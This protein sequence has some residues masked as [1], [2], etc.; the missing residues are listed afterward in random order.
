MNLKTLLCSC[1]TAMVMPMMAQ[2]FHMGTSVSPKG[3]TWTVDGTS[4]LHNGRRVIPVMGEIHFSR[5]PQSAWRTELLKMKAGGVNIIANYVFWIHH[6]EIEGQYDW[7]GQRNLRQFLKTCQELQLPVILRIGPFCHGEVRHGGIPDWAVNRGV[8]LRST[9]PRFLDMVGN[10]Y[11]QIYSQAQGLLWKDGGPVIGIQ[12]DNEYRGPWEYLITLKRLAQSVGFDVPIYTRTGW[13]QPTTPATFGELIPL[14]GDYSDGFWDRE[15][16][17]MPGDYSGCYFFKSYRGSTVIATEQLPQESSR[18]EERG[19]PFLTCELGGGMM[20][21]YHRRVYI[22]PED[23]YATALVKIANGSNLPGYYMYHGGTNPEGKLTTLN[24]MQRT[25]VTNYND[26]PVMTYDFQ[27]PLGEF[28]Q[29]RPHYHSLRM[30]HLFLGEW[31]SQLAVM[32]PVFPVAEHKDYS[33]DDSLRWNYRTD[34]KGG[35]VFVNNYQRLCRLSDKAGVRFTVKT[36][37]GALTFPSKPVSVASG[38]SF[39]VPFGMELAGQH[40]EYIMAQPITQI[41]VGNLTTVFFKHIKDIPAEYSLNHKV[42]TLHQGI[43]SFGKTLRVVLLDDNDA[44]RL[45][46]AEVAGKSRVLLADGSLRFDH[47]RIVIADTTALFRIGLYP[48]DVEV[49]PE[50]LQ[51][52]KFGIAKSG[53]FTEYSVQ[54]SQPVRTPVAL[55]KL[56]DAEGLRKITIGVNRAAEEPTDSDFEQ[57]AVWKLSVPARQTTDEPSGVDNPSDPDLTVQ[58]LLDISYQG[59]V[60]RLYE[61]TRLIDD[62]F[63]NGRHFFYDLNRLKGTGDLTLRILPYQKDAPVYIQRAFAIEPGIHHVGARVLYVNSVALTLSQK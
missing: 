24:E 48:A 60:A 36:D 59:D 8:K 1:L 15:L 25:K 42:G 41:Q 28:G 57:A 19:Y 17:D 63:Y 31:G 26:L 44:H 16:T 2:E 40:F 22:Y 46:K 12:C 27:A 14:Y 37:A 21:S 10:L 32:H 49:K 47:D 38:E 30:L 55:D 7:S 56:R 29:V 20:T 33:W 43:N 54:T 53:I 45:W 39:F 51:L 62:N 35:Y 3:D 18:G 52:T 9:A 50:A 4:L 61:G 13:P 58:P 6:E 5:V 23:N 34:G 11:R